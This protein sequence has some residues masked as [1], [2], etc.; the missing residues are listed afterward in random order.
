MLAFASVT[1][2]T[3]EWSKI[4]P[5]VSAGIIALPQGISMWRVS[6]PGKTKARG[7]NGNERAEAH[8]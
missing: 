5:L 2:L 7:E 1:I 3:E 8:G 6:A 4:L